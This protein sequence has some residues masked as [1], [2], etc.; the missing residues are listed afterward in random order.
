MSPVLLLA[1]LVAVTLIACGT[2]GLLRHIRARQLRSLAVQWRM[3]Y[4]HRDPFNLAERIGARLPLPAPNLRVLD[5]VHGSEASFH[6]YVFTVEFTQETLST[7]GRKRRVFTFCEP[8]DV[9][10]PCPAP[11]VA[12]PEE[13]P[14]LDQYRHLHDHNWTSS[15]RRP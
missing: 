7:Y 12:A 9:A 2:E 14:I 4:T 10:D 8:R 11:L 13:L 6:R 5:L 15:D 3:A 1:A